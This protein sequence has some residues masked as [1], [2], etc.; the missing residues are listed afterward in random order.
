MTQHSINY[1]IRY[2]AY[3]VTNDL[4]A[5]GSTFQGCPTW[6]GTRELIASHAA[7]LAHPH[8]PII[9][10]T[11]T[12]DGESRPYYVRMILAN[13]HESFEA[14]ASFEPLINLITR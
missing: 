4:F 10:Y 14:I 8:M 1:T 13:D 5:E 2:F 6:E 7:V 11:I 12:K 3:S 9:D